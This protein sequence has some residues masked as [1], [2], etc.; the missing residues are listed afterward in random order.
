MSFIKNINIGVKYM[1]FASFTFALMAA[2][3]KL[4]SRELSSLEVVFFRNLFGVIIISFV[5]YRSGVKSIGS[6][7]LLLFFRGLMGFLSLLAYFYNVAHISMGDAVT[8]SKTAPIFTAIFA[9]FFLNE[10]LPKSAWIAVFVGFI[11]IVLIAQPSGGGF[12]KYDLLG[13]FSGVGAALAYTSIREL[14][15]YYDTN[16]IVLSFVLVGTI[17]P[18][19]LFVI[20]NFFSIDELDF[21][22]AKFIMPSGIVWLYV[23]ALGVLGTIS[24]YYMTKAYATSKAGVVSAASYTNILF[25][26]LIGV[27]LGDNLPSFITTMGVLLVILAG[28]LVAQE[29]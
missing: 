2:F 18:L 1:L 17:G 4:A 25:A 16:V 12:S 8:Y 28:V 24:Q 9:W 29:K 20:G 11:G 7:P 22:V 13:I 19:I 23:V 14:R 3:A 21:L 5:I 6:K 15:R 10:K 26:I 27:A